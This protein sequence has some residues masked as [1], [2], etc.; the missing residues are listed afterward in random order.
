MLPFRMV[1][2]LQNFIFS[3]F[4]LTVFVNMNW[5]GLFTSQIESKEVLKELPTIDNGIGVPDLT[6]VAYL[7]VTWSCVSLI[8]IKGFYFTLFA[9]WSRAYI[10]L[11]MK[12]MWPC[13]SVDVKQFS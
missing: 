11:I 3:K 13:Y 9:I 10:F 2:R 12:E 4:C 7:V 6:L 5:F 8:L 1:H